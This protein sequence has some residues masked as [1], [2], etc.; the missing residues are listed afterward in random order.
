VLGW[1]GL[2]FALL[3]FV[4]WFTG[5]TADTGPFSP[6]A[7]DNASAVGMALSVAER[8]STQPLAHTEVWFAFTGCEETGCDGMLSFLEAYGEQLADALFVDF[9]LVG[10]GERLVYLQSEGMARKRRIPKELE[11]LLS[12]VGAGSGIQP[13]NAGR[14]G[15][16]TETGVLWERG[17]QGVTLLALRQGTPY[18]PEWHRLS[19]TADRLQPETLARVHDLAWAL[20]QEV[21]TCMQ[22]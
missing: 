2:A 9:E 17:F 1:V 18:L 14:F 7:N 11:D 10:I 5:M 22:A 20:L 8:L 4:A 16:F 19:D 6:G 13:V 21:D 12:R 3:H 15:A